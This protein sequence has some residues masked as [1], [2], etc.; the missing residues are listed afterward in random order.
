MKKKYN[1]WK[2]I[3]IKYL[4][5]KDLPQQVRIYLQLKDLPKMQYQKYKLVNK[6][7]NKIYFIQL[8][9]F[10]NLKKKKKYYC[11]IIIFLEFYNL[12]KMDNKIVKN[13]KFI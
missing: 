9:N 10:Q 2:K 13:K 11:L 1:T 5:L 3:K 7:L 8:K 6:I 12:L 4:Y